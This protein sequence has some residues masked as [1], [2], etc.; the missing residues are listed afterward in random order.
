MRASVVSRRSRVTRT[1]SAPRPLMRAGEHVVAR[2]LVDRQRLAGDRRLVDGARPATT[3]PS[4]G[5]F[6][7]GR[8]TMTAPCATCSTATRRSPAA[9][10]T[11][12]SAGVRSI[13]ARMAWRAR[14]SVRASSACAT[15]NRNTTV[16]ASDHWPSAAAPAAAISI[17]TLMSSEPTRSALHALR[18][19]RGDAG[20][21]RDHEAGERQGGRAEL[22]PAACRLQP[23]SASR[24]NCS[25]IP[26]ASATPDVQ[27]SAWRRRTCR[28]LPTIGSS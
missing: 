20:G 10:R 3:S 18:D 27:T 13:S 22:E 5:I 21:E 8:T 25:A 7:P 4:S 1:S 24:R 23:D 16:A 6:S 2:R 15:A 11:S 17:R 12:A 14:S 28:S 9:S 19:G 26:S